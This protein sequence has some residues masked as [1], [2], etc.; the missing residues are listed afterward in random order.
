M[1]T[2]VVT[3]SRSAGCFDFVGLLWTEGIAAGFKI[4]LEANP[5]LY[6]MKQAKSHSTKWSVHNVH[7]ETQTARLNC[8]KF[9]TTSVALPVCF[10]ERSAS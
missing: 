8:T 1:V 6:Y 9:T 2:V 10:A 7:A 5:V 4:R 3:F